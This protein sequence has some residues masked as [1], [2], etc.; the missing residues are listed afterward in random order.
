MRLFGAVQS[1]VQHDGEGAFVFE[2]VPGD[3][4]DGVQQ[5]V[6]ELL[7]EKDPIVSFA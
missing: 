1:T 3:L 2:G 4:Q 6:K 5:Q 7:P